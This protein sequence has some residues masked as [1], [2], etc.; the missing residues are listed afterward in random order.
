[1]VVQPGREA[2]VAAALGW[3]GE[4]IVVEGLDPAR[5]ALTWLREQDQGNA[6]MLV[7]DLA[8]ASTSRE[9]W[10]ELPGYAVWAADVV[11]A[12]DEG[13][14]GAV[15]GLLARVALVDDGDDAALFVRAVPGITAVT[16]D[17]DVYGPG[18]VRGGSSSTP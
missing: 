14:T 15:H 16:P 9:G 13:L 10:P 3:A 2:A 4:A 11:R 7:P 1:L 12:S 17:G 8:T 6:G 18:W 5:Q